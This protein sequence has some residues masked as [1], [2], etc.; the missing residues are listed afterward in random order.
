MVKGVKE[1]VGFSKRGHKRVYVTK[2][3]NEEEEKEGGWGEG[4]WGEL[5]RNTEELRVNV[6][7]V[8]GVLGLHEEILRWG[9]D[10]GGWGGRRGGRVGRVGL[11]V[12]VSLNQRY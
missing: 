8:E 12:E 10:G 1:G 11:M 3:G 4:G 7:S 2:A 9:G 6:N 5:L